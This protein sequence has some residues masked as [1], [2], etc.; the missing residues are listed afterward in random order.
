[1]NQ[2]WTLSGREFKIEIN[3][4]NMCAQDITKKSSRYVCECM[5]V[6]VCVYAC[7]HSCMHT[8][9]AHKFICTH[10]SGKTSVFCV[11]K[12]QN[13]TFK[14]TG[15]PSSCIHLQCLQTYIHTYIH[16][17]THN[18][19]K[20]ATCSKRREKWIL[21]RHGQVCIYVCMFSFLHKQRHICWI[22]EC[23]Y[24]CILYI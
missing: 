12:I 17:H 13:T 7:M 6:C 19:G 16:T 20:R 18:T 9:Y 24:E 22:Y 8:L 11:G 2:V 14:H 10:A 3:N 21:H 5:C 15:T 1:M 4:S 23:I